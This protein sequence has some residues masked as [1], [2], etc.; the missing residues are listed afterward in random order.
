MTDLR[1]DPADARAIASLHADAA[2]GI[3][4]AG[5]SAPGSVDAGAASATI[6]SILSRVA[7]EAAD[8]AVC[9]RG[10]EET[11]WQTADNYE[12]TEESVTSQFTGLTS[13]VPE[14]WTQ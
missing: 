14:G 12:A 8:L 10:A 4:D 13:S 6:H 9:H 2:Q 1:I 3:E 7:T 5:G 11:M